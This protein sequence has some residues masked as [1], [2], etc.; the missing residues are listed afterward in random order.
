M[1]KRLGNNATLAGQQFGRL[2][3]MGV[4]PERNK[5]GQR[6]WDCSCSC[7]NNTT[8]PTGRL[9][10]GTTASCGCGQADA[11]RKNAGRHENLLGKT[12]GM[13][14]VE[15][16]LERRAKGSQRVWGCVCQCGARTE[17]TTGNLNNGHIKGCGCT[18]SAA[19]AK[20]WA[21]RK[22]KHP[23]GE[24]GF[25]YYLRV[26]KKS[27]KERGLPFF[28]TPPQVKILAKTDCHYCGAAPGT[29]RSGVGTPSRFKEHNTF[30]A[31][32]IDRKDNARGYA[33][34]NVVACCIRCNIAKHVMSYEEFLA[35]MERIYQ[36]LIETG[37]I[38]AKSECSPG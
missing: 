5:Q 11:L 3:V 33:A 21:Q 30:V 19:N 23:K 17:V 18:R 26:Y 22:S 29:P 10:N 35:H 16:L 15:S 9:R 1:G 6:R 31:N 12:F 20:D 32:G 34:D 28:L 14:R 25:R 13:L 8:V 2:T 4:N 7:G 36:N 37:G 38:T 24:I 27:A